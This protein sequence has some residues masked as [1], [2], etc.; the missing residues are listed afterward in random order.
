MAKAKQRASALYGAP[1]RIHKFQARKL[2]VVAVFLLFISLFHF[3]LVSRENRNALS[4]KYAATIYHKISP[5][6]SH[7]L[8]SDRWRKDKRLHDGIPST[9]YSRG[10]LLRNRPDWKLL[11]SGFEGDAYT[12]DGVVIKAYRTANAPFRN[13]VPGLDLELRWPT[14]ISAALVLGGLA[15]RLDIC[16]DASY[17]PVVDYFLA[18]VDDEEHEKWYFVTPFLSSGNLKNL[19]KR[20]RKSDTAYDAQQLDAL[21][22]PSFERVLD[23]LHD[24]HA[25]HGLCHDDI[26]PDNIFLN[27]SPGSESNANETVHWLLADFGNVRETNNAYHHSII[28]TRNNL[29][30]C[31]ANDVFRLVKSYMKFLRRSVSDR[32]RF[33][34]EFFAGETAWSRLFWSTWQ[35]VQLKHPITAVR[36]K[37]R[38]QSMDYQPSSAARSSGFGSIPV[39]LTDP[40]SWSLMGRE[41]TLERA[42]RDKL[43]IG[44]TE[45]PAR[46]FGLTPALGIPVPDC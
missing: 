21:F 31:R 40:V 7:L 37:Q 29:P 26:K 9:D 16:E 1:P 22:R 5:Q 12:Y 23:S 41:K 36:L 38:S 20:L 35:T 45:I 4:Q 6:S 44:A 42:V 30:D 13:C 3:V 2:R 32:A 14:E 33:N 43:F 8:A 28:W 46:L 11:G 10:N 34:E 24:M 25:T 17:L 39:E 15:D 27:S 19:A 18:P